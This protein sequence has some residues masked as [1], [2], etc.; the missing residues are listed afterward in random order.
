MSPGGGYRPT[1]P[2]LPS[3]ALKGLEQFVPPERP[4]H[5]SLGPSWKFKP[6]PDPPRE[7]CNLY[8]T[9]DEGEVL[10]GR[11]HD[12][13]DSQQDTDVSHNRRQ[14]E[15]LRQFL[16]ENFDYQLVTRSS[17]NLARQFRLPNPCSSQ[18]PHRPN[19]GQWSLFPSVKQLP[20]KV[21]RRN[22]VAA[23]SQETQWRRP[24]DPTS[25]SSTH[26]SLMPAPL[27][28]N[29]LQIW[30]AD[31]NPPPAPVP[32]SIDF[33]HCHLPHPQHYATRPGTESPHPRQPQDFTPARSIRNSCSRDSILEASSQ[34]RGIPTRQSLDSQYPNRTQ[35]YSS[36]S[37]NSNR[38]TYSDADSEDGYDFIQQDET[39][40]LT[41]P[42]QSPGP[43]YAPHPSGMPFHR[44]S[45]FPPYTNNRPFIERPK[46]LAIPP[47]D[48]QKYGP[49]V[50][51]SQRKQYRAALFPRFLRKLLPRSWRPPDDENDKSK[52]DRCRRSIGNIISPKHTL[53]PSPYPRPPQSPRK[54][55]LP[56]TLL[57]AQ[58]PSLP[59]LVFPRELD[60]EEYFKNSMGDAD[61]GETIHLQPTPKPDGSTS[62]STWDCSGG[63]LDLFPSK[64]RAD[65]VADLVAREGVINSQECGR[66]QKSR[67]EL[68]LRGRDMLDET[69]NYWL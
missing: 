40:R 26:P 13:L 9:Y 53:Y 21:K 22:L 8:D 45:A 60:I 55:P 18:K 29:G 12:F 48:Y 27:A 37:S 36:P 57:S 2:L 31:D 17:E 49:K 38:N 5:A 61:S 63:G 68:A 66:M 59:S 7:A 28:I 4:A 3:R 46:Q 69:L 56:P 33:C 51:D 1:P 10:I 34:H 15:N 54:A 67:S 30:E 44:S 32:E 11:G 50:F 6:L 42:G 20:R 16:D 41:N 19:E 65:A 62:F 24:S 43:P 14:I 52:S 39:F 25:V 47:T 35:L 23:K 58:P 64:G